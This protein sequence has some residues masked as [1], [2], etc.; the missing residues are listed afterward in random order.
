MKLTWA[1]VRAF[2]L[3]RQHLGARV[4]RERALEVASRLCGLHAQV[5]SS[6][7]LTLWARVDGLEPDAVRRMLWEERSL[8]KQWAMRGTLHLL[9][10]GEL[11]LWHSA[12]STYSHFRRP[13]WSRATGIA[14]EE[15][16]AYVAAVG[17]V[18]S[19]RTMTRAELAEAVSARTGIANRTLTES[20]GSVLKP[21]AFAGRLCFAPDAGRHVSFTNPGTWVGETQ[22]PPAEQALA[23]VARRFLTAHGPATRED[24]ARWWAT[25]PARAGRLIAGL[26]GALEVDVAGEAM[27]MLE[28]DAQAARAAAAPHGIRLLPGFDQ[29]VIGSTRHVERLMPGPHG[30]R[31]HRPQGWVSPVLLV[32]GR[33]DGVWRHERKGR[34]LLVTIEPFVALRARDRR[35]AEAEA[36]SLAE[37]LG[38]Q[39]DLRWNA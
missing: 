3:E 7:E 39:L 30:A 21:A 34:R 6:A 16:D 24:L 31:V 33:M 37:F 19:G 35:A 32:G 1:Q 5:L 28:A 25:T 23:E 14:Q 9:P 26:D 12:L 4:G 13:S 36:E 20:W 8:V 38:G 22:G 10:A 17:D 2:R 29:Y 27:W 15:L 11:G 18:L